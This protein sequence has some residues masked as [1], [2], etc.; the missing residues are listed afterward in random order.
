MKVRE[1]H[2]TISVNMATWPRIRIGIDYFTV[3]VQ[4]QLLCLILTKRD[5]IHAKW[6]LPIPDLHAS[7]RFHKTERWILWMSV[8][9]P[10]RNGYV[11]LIALV[12]DRNGT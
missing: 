8:H 2:S 3:L 12:H 6:A 9:Q 1:I 10:Y 7:R 11:V 5:T 4:I